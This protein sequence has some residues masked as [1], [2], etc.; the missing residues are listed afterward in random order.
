MLSCLVVAA[1]ILILPFQHQASANIGDQT[2]EPEMKHSDVRQ[3]Q[4]LLKFKGYF[5]PSGSY[6]N[7]Y[8]ESTT[9]AVK[10][11]QKDHKLKKSGVTDRSTFNALGVYNIDNT[12]LIEK[13]KEYMGVPY[14]WGGTSPKGFDCS[15]FIYYVFEKSQDV[16]LPRTAADLYS[17]VGLKTSEPEPG[18]LVFFKSGKRVTH[19]GIYIGDNEFIHSATSRGVSISSMDNTYWKPKYLG[20]KTL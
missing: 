12:K 20:S 13:A 10:D 16:V 8:N 18:D 9:K 17:K 4:K 1:A 7:H 15:G 11:F 19:V 2:L 6:S 3:L 5:K 14:R